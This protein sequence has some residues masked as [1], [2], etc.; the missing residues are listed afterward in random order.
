MANAT[1]PI[2]DDILPVMSENKNAPPQKIVVQRR[3]LV[4]GDRLTSGVVK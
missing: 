3:V 4:S 2:G 1:A